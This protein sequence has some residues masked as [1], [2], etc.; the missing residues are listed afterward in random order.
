MNEKYPR[1]VEVTV[2]PVVINKDNKIL[3][4]KSPKWND[5]YMFA[6][7]HIEPGEKM[8]DALRRESKEEFGADVDVIDFLHTDEYF[9]EPPQFKR[10]AHFI[11]FDILCKIK[12]GETI[13]LDD[14]ELKDMAW[15]TIDEAIEKSDESC[16]DTLKTLKKRIESGEK[17]FN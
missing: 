3:M 14:D 8:F 1:G 2:G 7:G 16:Q 12:D 4:F 11:C 15:L 5:K 9:V 6:G 17:F 10:P 13:K